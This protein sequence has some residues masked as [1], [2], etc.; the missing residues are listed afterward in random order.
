MQAPH[1]NGPGAQQWGQCLCP[2][3]SVA[4]AGRRSVVER[5]R[6]SRVTRR[7]AVKSLGD[8]GGTRSSASRPRRCRPRKWRP[9]DRRR[10]RRLLLGSVR[11]GCSTAAPLP[12]RCV[13][14]G[15]WL[16]G[17]IGR[18][19]QVPVERF[20]VVIWESRPRD[21]API[22]LPGTRSRARLGGPRLV[23]FP[24]GDRVEHQVTANV[25]R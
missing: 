7:F 18:S 12:R 5:G 14:S 25:R 2:P 6:K 23:G 20:P 21:K 17:A 13:T 9:W 8:R 15:V 1:G 10:G 4:V 24:P 11:R 19:R 3:A 22:A 16:L